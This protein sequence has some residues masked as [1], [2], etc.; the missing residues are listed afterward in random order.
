VAH[1]GGQ[2]VVIA[3]AFAQEGLA[4]PLL[5]DR[6]YQEFASFFNIIG[7][8]YLNPL[9]IS[10]NVLS[11]EDLVKS[12]NIL[13]GDENIDCLV[14]ELCLPFLAQIWEYYPSYL[15]HLLETLVGFRATCA[16]C[17]SIVLIAGQR[18]AEALKIRRKLID[19]G[20]PSFPTFERAAK[21]L[22][23]IVDYY[24]FHGD[25]D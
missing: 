3:D 24:R 22:K 18:E 7:G 21:A 8:S 15:D 19:R 12:L 25:Q 6:A 20:L 5:S 2:S 23:K 14:L 16:K 17:F 10:W 4:V 13:S 9:D 11:T 1:S